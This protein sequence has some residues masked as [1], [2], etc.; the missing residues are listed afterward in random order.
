MEP[1]RQYAERKGIGTADYVNVNETV[2]GATIDVKLDPGN[3]GTNNLTVDITDDGAPF[4]HAT[5]IRARVKY[6]DDDFGEYFIPLTNESPGD[7]RLDNITI[8]VAGAYQ[9][10]VTVVPLRLLRLS[11]S[12]PD[13]PLNPTP[14]PQTSFDHPPKL[15]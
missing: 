7:W 15:S 4:L 2:V 5:D 11:R 6:L 9:L 14:S 1:A 8:G 10:D 13:S 12:P 3:T